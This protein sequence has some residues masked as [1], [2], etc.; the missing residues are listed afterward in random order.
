MDT[1]PGGRS[2]VLRRIGADAVF[3]A[4]LLSSESAG[5]NL[6]L[7]LPQK[8]KDDGLPMPGGIVSNS[9]VVQFLHYAYSYYENAF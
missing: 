4:L 1:F 2:A 7:A 5:G 6:V 3:G 9:P 8:L